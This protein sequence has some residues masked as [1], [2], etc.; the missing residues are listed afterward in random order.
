[1]LWNSASN[2]M[3]LTEVCCL[4]DSTVIFCEHSKEY[5]T[6]LGDFFHQLNKPEVVLRHAVN[7][8]DKLFHSGLFL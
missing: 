5:S 8:V 7:F 1:M 6:K 2:E 4:L 3:D